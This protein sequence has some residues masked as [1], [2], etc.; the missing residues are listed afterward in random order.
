M[1]N[2]KIAATGSSL[3]LKHTVDPASSIGIKWTGIGGEAVTGRPLSDVM[4][5]EDG[6]GLM[7][8]FVLG[9]IFWSPAF[10]AVYMAE[11]VWRKW[12]SPS[13]EKHST[14]DGANL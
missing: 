7:Q 4:E 8:L 14:P 10:G 1:K 9:A 12:S 5:L 2:L 13:V 6:I 11:R 3:S